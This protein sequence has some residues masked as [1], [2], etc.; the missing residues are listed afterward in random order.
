MNQ[1]LRSGH[2][3]RGGGGGA[4]YMGG[5][6]CLLY[7]LALGDSN[8]PLSECKSMRRAEE[9]A[10]EK[11]VAAAHNYPTR[12]ILRRTGIGSG[13]RGLGNGKWVLY[14]WTISIN[15]LKVAGRTS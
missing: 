1:G 13:E 8:L 3:A 7:R 15:K 5:E 14:S 4:A 6:G 9:Q 12:R 11:V 10:A 2:G